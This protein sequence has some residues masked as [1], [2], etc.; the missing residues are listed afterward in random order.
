MMEVRGRERCEKSKLSPADRQ[1]GGEIHGGR[2]GGEETGRHITTAE[3]QLGGGGEKRGG[4]QREREN[5]KKIE[6]EGE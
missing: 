1:L 2:D 5:E 6:I 3:R 4:R